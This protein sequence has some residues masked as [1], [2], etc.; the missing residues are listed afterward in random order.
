MVP[1]EESA[2]AVKEF[3]TIADVRQELRGARSNQGGTKIWPRRTRGARRNESDPERLAQFAGIGLKDN[4]P[5]LIVMNPETGEERE[6][7]PEVAKYAHLPGFKEALER[8]VKF[9]GCLP[10]SVSMHEL[11]IGDDD[12]TEVFAAL[13]EAP[14]ESYMPSPGQKRS[15]KKGSIWVH[16]YEG[17]KPMKAVDG[18]GKLI[19]TIPGKHKVTDWIHG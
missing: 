14:A 3:S 13:G 12:Q 17:S 15:N 19:I 8:Y 11:P 7:S 6:L 9:H 1:P 18:S 2:L 16:E 4:P 10:D 5:L